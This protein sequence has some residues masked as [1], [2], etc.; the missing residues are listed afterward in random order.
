MSIGFLMGSRLPVRLFLHV[1]S[2]LTAAMSGVFFEVAT[3]QGGGIPALS[4]GIVMFITALVFSMMAFVGV[5]GAEA[6]PH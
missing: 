4:A 2:F 3:V 1:I 6:L 5:Q